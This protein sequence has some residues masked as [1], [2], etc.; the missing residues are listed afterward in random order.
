MRNVGYDV[1]VTSADADMPTAT[2]SCS[3][4][5]RCS[6]S[7]AFACAR[8]SRRAI[9][10]VDLVRLEGSPVLFSGDTLFPG[11]PGNTT[12]EGGDFVTII[13]S[14]DTKLFPL[15][16]DTIVLPGHGEDTTIGNERPHLQEWAELAGE[17]Q[18][19]TPTMP[20]WPPA[21]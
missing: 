3:R 9:R 13:Q 7:A 1:G 10:R 12:F 11:G 8:S 15:P 21:P 20:G 18:R 14:L 5:T 4:T 6:R 19:R 17:L 2:T 16:E